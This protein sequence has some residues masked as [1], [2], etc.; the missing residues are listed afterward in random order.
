MS[1]SEGKTARRDEMRFS[2]KVK[3]EKVKISAREK[4]EGI[5]IGKRIKRN[6]KFTLCSFKHT[7]ST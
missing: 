7:L 6:E 5:N 2:R 1:G 4:N 3:N